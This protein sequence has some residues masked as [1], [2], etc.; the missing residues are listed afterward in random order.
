[1]IARLYTEFNLDS[2]AARVKFAQLVAAALPGANVGRPFFLA[3]LSEEATGA[4]GL[5]VWADVVGADGAAEFVE[6]AGAAV[7]GAAAVVGA[8]I[9]RMSSEAG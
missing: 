4:H 5:T 1:M 8:R 2:T 3:G 7:H 9:T 6:A